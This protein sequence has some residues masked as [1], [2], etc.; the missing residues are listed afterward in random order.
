LAV[1]VAVHLPLHLA[2]VALVVL[3]F[4]LV[5]QGLH[6]QQQDVVLVAV[7]DI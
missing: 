6:L 1:A 3:E 5:E 2:Q 7:V 4:L